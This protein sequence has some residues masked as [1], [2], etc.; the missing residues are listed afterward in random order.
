MYPPVDPILL[1]LGPLVLRWYGLL[2][3]SGVLAAT[4]VAARYVARKGEDPANIWDM[5]IWVLIPGLI[6]ARLYYV[7]IQSP[8]GP[9][10]LDRY[11]ADPVSILRVWEGGLHIFG[12]ALFG[13]IAVYLYARVRKLPMLVYLDGIALGLPLGQAIGRQANFVNQELYGTPT[14][15]PWGLRIDAVYRVPPY[16]NLLLYPDSARFHPLFLYESLWNLLGFGLIFWFQ[17][18][19]ER[20]LRLGD[21]V[22]LYLIWYPLG[23]FFIELLRADGDRLAGTPFNLAHLISA[24]CVVGAAATLYWRH[25]EVGARDEV[26]G[27][28]AETTA[29][30]GEVPADNAERAADSAEPVADGV[31]AVGVT[32]DERP[33][34]DTPVEKPT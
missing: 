3:M 22:L 21:I 10:G 6:G 30:D 28:S 11:L 19:Y 14:T 17:R 34:S 32:A 27:S 26:I 2:I 4:W 18:R 9:D 23:R 16:D 7:F 29:D 24:L 31:E 25:R 1:E 20:A 5:L 15:L 12:G 8:R 13:V 33:A